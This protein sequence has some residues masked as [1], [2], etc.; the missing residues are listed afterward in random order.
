MLLIVFVLEIIMLLWN[1][2]RAAIGTGG[3]PVIAFV[4]V[5]FSP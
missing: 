3:N 4:I 5:K 2:G 1:I